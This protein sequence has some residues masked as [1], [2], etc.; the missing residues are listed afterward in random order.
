M[1]IL[2]KFG[3]KIVFCVGR[4]CSY[5]SNRQVSRNRLLDPYPDPAREP[6]KL[7][8]VLLLCPCAPCARCTW[9][10]WCQCVTTFETVA[11]QQ[12]LVVVLGKEWS[13]GAC[14]TGTPVRAEELSVVLAPG[15]R[16][17]MSSPSLC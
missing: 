13:A 15:A 17:E 11:Y 3:K 6:S 14:L 1:V 16:S 2:R 12:W 4:V 8:A 9:L 7:Q 10:P 5:R